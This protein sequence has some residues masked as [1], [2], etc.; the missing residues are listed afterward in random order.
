MEQ[1]NTTLNSEI[2]SLETQQFAN[3]ERQDIEIQTPE[4]SSS[5]TK[6]GIFWTNIF[7]L[8][9]VLNCVFVKIAQK[10]GAS[11]SMVVTARYIVL[12]AL[13]LFLQAGDNPTKKF[14][15][16]KKHAAFGRFAIG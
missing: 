2:D 4:I 1:L 14:P 9:T 11:L 7:T 16:E 8:A 5:D 13:S 3:K 15:W 10:E 6:W 12:I